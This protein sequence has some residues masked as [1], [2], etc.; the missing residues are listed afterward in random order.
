M[1]HDHTQLGSCQLAGCLSA[2]ERRTRGLPAGT[3]APKHELSKV[4]LRMARQLRARK[5]NEDYYQSG[6]EWKAPR[7]RRAA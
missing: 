4:A 6:S 1:K 7:S 5:D 3:L 2:E